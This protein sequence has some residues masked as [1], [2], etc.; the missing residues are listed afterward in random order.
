MNALRDGA[1]THL[2]L[3]GNFVKPLSL[4][5][6]LSSLWISEKDHEETYG[7]KSVASEMKHDQLTKRIHCGLEHLSAEFGDLVQHVNFKE[8]DKQKEALWPH[9]MHVLGKT[10]LANL[11]LSNCNIGP[12]TLEVYTR[13]IGHN[14]LQACTTNLKILNLRGNPLTKDGAKLL[15]TA[16]EQ[17]TSI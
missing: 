10:K 16:M 3:E 14:P 8:L 9:I 15:S 5:S 6:F 12:K 1:L 4:V 11:Q 7:D 13:A 17:N 2:C